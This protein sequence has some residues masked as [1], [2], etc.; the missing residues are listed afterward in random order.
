[1]RNILVR[2][3]NAP[4]SFDAD[5]KNAWG[6]L[7][8]LLEQADRNK[9]AS[10]LQYTITTSTPIA[11]SATLNTTTATYSLT[12]TTITLIKLINDLKGGG[13]LG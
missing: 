4:A 3:P 2:Y 5:A 7:V 9:L 12:A 10:G 13:I 1:M 8:Q 11:T 6:R